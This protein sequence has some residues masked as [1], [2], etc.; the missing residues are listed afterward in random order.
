MSALVQKPRKIRMLDYQVKAPSWASCTLRTRVR[1]EPFPLDPGALV[2]LVLG[3]LVLLVLGALVLL[4]LGGLGGGLGLDFFFKSRASSS[5]SN[6]PPSTLAAERARIW[7]TSA[8]D[9]DT[10][11]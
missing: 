4:M 10:C 6:N 5:L 1:I 3:A 7:S 9:D 8:P 2:L 11:K